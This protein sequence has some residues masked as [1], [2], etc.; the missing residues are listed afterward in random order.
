MAMFYQN[1]KTKSAR[2]R[3]ETQLEYG[4]DFAALIGAAF[5]STVQER[6]RDMRAWHMRGCDP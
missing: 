2:M 5:P 4:D 6:Q 3:V 1:G